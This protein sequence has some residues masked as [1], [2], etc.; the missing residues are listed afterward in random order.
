[1]AFKKS[2]LFDPKDQN[3]SRFC[4]AIAYPVRVDILFYLANHPETRVEVLY[5]K[6]PLAK[7]TIS[8]HLKILRE[9]GLVRFH[10]KYPYNLYSLDWKNFSQL[11]H[12]L[13]E[14]L[15]KF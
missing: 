2:H 3:I 10:E 12:V 9:S 15:N 11:R 14:Y 8:D 13:Q 5:R 4:S 7:S 6:Y 1:M